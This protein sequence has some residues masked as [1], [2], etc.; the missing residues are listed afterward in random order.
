MAARKPTKKELESFETHLRKMLAELTGDIS[1]LEQETLGEGAVV[2]ES[3]EE[4]GTG[5]YAREV[6]LGLLEN[7][8]SI[9]REIMD[10]LDRIKEGTYG[11][12]DACESWINKE[13]LKAVPH[14][15]NCIE[16]QRRMEEE[17]A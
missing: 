16:C 14:A 3:P 2:N 10:A 7:D 8:E 9:V 4:G 1:K 12:C 6:S 17:V 5:G 11:R 13:R 15:R